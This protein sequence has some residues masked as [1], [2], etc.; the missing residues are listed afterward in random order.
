LKNIRCI[1]FSYPRFDTALK[2]IRKDMRYH[3]E[4]F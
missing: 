3:L 4:N 1:I 2:G